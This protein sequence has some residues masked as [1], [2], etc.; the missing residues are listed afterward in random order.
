[1]SHTVTLKVKFKNKEALKKALDNLGIKLKEGNHEVNL[2]SGR[3]QCEASF[4][5]PGWRYPVAVCGEELKYDNYGGSWGKTDQLHKVQ[6]Q[7]A[8]EVTIQEAQDSGMFVEE[9]ETE[10][11]SIEL[12]LYT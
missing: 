11:G 8:K 3:I 7:Y 9:E 5:L 1:V 6:Q 10:D 2:Y 4:K 12:Y